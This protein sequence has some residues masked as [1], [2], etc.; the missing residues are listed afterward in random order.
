MGMVYH[1]AAAGH[2]IRFL[3]GAAKVTKGFEIP[4]IHSQLYVARI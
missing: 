1:F 2:T 4:V 3:F